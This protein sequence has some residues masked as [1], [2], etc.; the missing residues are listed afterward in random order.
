MI[1][2]YVVRQVMAQEGCDW[3]EACRILGERAA[4]ARKRK[5]AQAAQA[6][7][8]NGA[9]EA[10]EEQRVQEARARAAAICG[11]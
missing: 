10:Q 11:E 8:D 6:A 2:N 1:P 4:A 3:W 5:R 7:S 9:R